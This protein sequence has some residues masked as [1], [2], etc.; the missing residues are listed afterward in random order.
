[1]SKEDP[2]TE[3][4]IYMQK[5]REGIPKPMVRFDQLSG[6]VYE[7]GALST[8][9][10]AAIAVGIAVAKR[11]PLCI[12]YYTKG[13]LDVGCNK[14]EL[15]EAGGVAVMLGGGPAMVYIQYLLQAIERYEGK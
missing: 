9:L 6:A 10:K 15:L 14:Q 7:E 1:M 3:L 12:A 4:E 11:C 2:L 8:K 13:A 5:T